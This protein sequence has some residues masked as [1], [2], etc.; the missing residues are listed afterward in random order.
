MLADEADKLTEFHR[1]RVPRDEGPVT[2]SVGRSAGP[3]LI[4]RMRSPNLGIK[5]ERTGQDD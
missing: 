2:P 1:A 3:S 4:A 5:H